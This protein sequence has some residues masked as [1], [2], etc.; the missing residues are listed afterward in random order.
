MVHGVGVMVSV[1]GGTGVEVEGGGGLK[2]L[3]EQAQV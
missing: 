2:V 3:F 1:C